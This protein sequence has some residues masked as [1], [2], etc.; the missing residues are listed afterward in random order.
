V[1]VVMLVIDPRELRH[2]LGS[3]SNGPK[4]GGEVVVLAHAQKVARPE[5]FEPPTI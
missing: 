5:G 1:L 2:R 4:Y 3:T